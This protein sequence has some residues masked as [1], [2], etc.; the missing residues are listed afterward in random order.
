MQSLLRM[1]RL[2]VLGPVALAL[3]HCA[4]STAPPPASVALG[5]AGPP[6]VASIPAPPEPAPDARFPAG[7]GTPLVDDAIND[8]FR[9][10]GVVDRTVSQANRVAAAQKL[11]GV[12]GE[13]EGED[14]V[15]R[16]VTPRNIVGPFGCRELR[17]T[18]RETRLAP[19][20]HHACGLPYVSQPGMS[21]YVGAGARFTVR[22]LERVAA[23]LPLHPE[24]IKALGRPDDESPV[25]RTWYGVGAR[26]EDA[27]IS[28]HA[29]RVGATTRVEAAPLVACAI[30]WPP[31]A[32]AFERGPEL[33]PAPYRARVDA[34][35][36]CDASQLCLLDQ[37]TPRDARITERDGQMTAAYIDGRPA[38]I[39]ITQTCI[40]RPPACSPVTSA[41]LW[42]APGTTPP[43]GLSSG[44]CPAP[45]FHAFSIS[46]PPGKPAVLT[47]QRWNG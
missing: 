40:A 33:P 29:L 3:V 35:S 6:R 5:D 7:R 2:L 30:T 46:A 44:P 28:C 16:A 1:K 32:S 4:A 21:A 18:P 15:F 42:G 27:P 47:C 41:C 12:D 38:P 17:I 19:T 22:R 37:Q 13:H 25:D 45:G 34:C 43:I 9:E 36:A 24:A 11:L 26:T 14:W 10:H 23:D 20:D 39:T 31:P 8:A